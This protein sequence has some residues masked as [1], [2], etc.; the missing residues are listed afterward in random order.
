[1]ALQ[2]TSGP[3]AVGCATV[4]LADIR[5]LRGTAGRLG[6]GTWGLTEEASLGVGWT[7]S[8]LKER[9]LVKSTVLQGPQ[10]TVRI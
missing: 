7:T 6:R 2:Q 8:F 10:M 4:A 5:E 3:T 1:M 9:G